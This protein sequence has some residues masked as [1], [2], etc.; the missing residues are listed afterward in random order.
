MY[1]SGNRL[2]MKPKQY[3]VGG[4][5]E[6]IQYGVT[7]CIL[8][9]VLVAATERG[10]CSIE[11]GDDVTALVLQTQKRFP[12][13]T[14]KKAGSDFKCVIEDVVDFVHTPTSDFN[15]PLDIQGTV[16][17]QKVWSVLKDIEPGKTMSYTE[18]AEKIGNPHAVRAVATACAA[19]KLAVVIPCHRV[20]SKSG[21]LSG[22]RWGVARK[23]ALLENE[24]KQG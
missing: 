17:Q 3:K 21:K 22:Y 11:L 1:V 7:E 5:G 10:I 14:I 15:L 4:K 19:N 9:W 23:K 24:K 16:F 18:V 6:T 12:A 13:A 2:A 8:G 20:I